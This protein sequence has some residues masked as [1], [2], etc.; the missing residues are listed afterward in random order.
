[1]K[2]SELIWKYIHEQTLLLRKD[3]PDETLPTLSVGAIA[4]K[5]G[6]LPNNVSAE[7]GK[8][9][10]EQKLIR[11]GGRPAYYLD[12]EI[13]RT[14]CAPAVLPAS[15]G[16]LQE[17]LQFFSPKKQ[18]FSKTPVFAPHSSSLRPFAAS[19]LDSLIG[20]RS[21][22][23]RQI[24]QAKAA[25]LYPPHGLHTLLTGPTGSGKSLFAQSMHDYAVKSGAFGSSSPFIA[26]NCANYAENPQLLLSL[27][28]GH[29]KGAFTGATT[30]HA[31]IVEQ[32]DG[33]IL[34][35]DEVHRLTPEGQEK[36]FYLMDY[37][38][39]SRLGESSR[40]HADILI[41]C[42]TTAKAEEIMLD[43]FQRRIPAQIAMP[44]LHE[45]SLEERLELVLYFIWKEARL[46]NRSIAIDFL[47]LCAL[48]YYDCPANIGQL[49]ADIKLI[50]ARCN[51]SMLTGEHTGLCISEH[52]LHARIMQGLYTAKN[53]R[54]T[55]LKNI[56][57]TDKPITVFPS[58]NFGS[59]QTA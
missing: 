24:E 28:F 11:I 18:A 43:T 59:L 39:F 36:M 1:M 14:R 29:I 9:M 32:A 7:A 57:K 54:N 45:R 37:G 19:S 48:C 47:P 15:F 2:R 40:R 3:S 6:I 22:L 5:T 50:C 44:A 16:C 4:E 17:F 53:G 33:G 34:F 42:A 23:L 12:S 25:L 10:R 8:L 30:D 58:E 49:S 41:I 26:F 20:G 55:L 51:F 13:L 21:S 56:L 52:H 31:G 38:S 46:L 35:L 27:L